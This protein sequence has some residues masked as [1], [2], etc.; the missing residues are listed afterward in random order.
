MRKGFFTK[1]YHPP[2]TAPGT[3]KAV[4]H[5]DIVHTRIHVV[6]YDAAHFT[7]FHDASINDCRDSL[8]TGGITWIHVQGHSN[9]EILYSLGELLDLHSLA[10]EDILNSGQRPKAEMYHEQAFIIASLPVLKDKEVHLEQVS[11]FLGHNYVVSFYSSDDQPFEPILQYL[12]R[13]VERIRKRGADYLLYCLLDIV[14]DRGFPVLEHF[15]DRLEQFEEV[16]LESPDKTALSDLHLIKR[17]LLMLRRLLWP[18]REMINILLRDQP[19]NIGAETRIYL[20]DCYDHTIQIMDLLET[21]RDIAAD[22][23]DIY[24]SSNSQKLNENMRVLTVIATLFIPPTF[25]TG[26]YGMNFDRTAGPLNMPELGWAYGYV[27]ILAVIVLMT[28]GML[29]YFRLKK[30]F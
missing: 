19:E 23:L 22:M 10:L 29:A 4:S 21:Y 2:G 12:R 8:K 1:R 30:W 7:E 25:I 20:R 18:Q 13:N 5:K 24:L 11:F 3:L 16:L 27:L 26:L 6:N 17:E 14:I 28:I 15:G 9:P